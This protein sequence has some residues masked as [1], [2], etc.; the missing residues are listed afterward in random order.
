MNEGAFDGVTRRA[1]NDML[2]ELYGSGGAGP[3]GPPGP[4]GP[5]GA[6]GPPGNPGST[7][8][9]GPAGSA[10]PTGPV[11]AT[12]AQ[13]PAGPA[14]ASG[15]TGATGPQGPAG[16]GIQIKG[17]VPTSADLPATGAPGEG[18][19][20]A[21]TGHLWTWDA[22]NGVWVDAGQI[23]GP[24]GPAGPTGATGPAGTQGAAGA[25]GPTGATGATGQT[26]A[27][28]PQGATGPQGLQG[29]TGA[30]GATGPQGPLPAGAGVWGDVAFSAG[31][32]SGITVAAA[33]VGEHAYAQIGSVVVLTVALQNISYVGGTQFAV[34]TPYFTM[35][36]NSFESCWFY[37]P[38]IGWESGMWQGMSGQNYCL[39]QRANQSAFP[40]GA[41]HFYGTIVLS[42]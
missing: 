20:T 24:P 36:R 9:T 29:P 28:G 35:T 40:S 31:N 12:G 16:T 32:Y 38:G 14:G 4:P 1:I 34:L 2:A 27:Q 25:T 41:G 23:E 37:L 3:Q 15:P 19:I 6:Q 13:G 11:G 21:D 18:W 10:G 17:T 7:G 22:T 5:S 39:A 33:N 8:A 42:V 26:G 30:T